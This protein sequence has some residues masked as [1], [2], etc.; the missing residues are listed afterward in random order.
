[1]VEIIYRTNVV[2]IS[3]SGNYEH[4]QICN[5]YNN[6]FSIIAVTIQIEVFEGK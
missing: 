1:M 4:K 2:R 5:L 6:E 3:N